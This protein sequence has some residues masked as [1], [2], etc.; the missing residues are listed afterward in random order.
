MSIS[1]FILPSTTLSH[2]S[3]DYRV[4]SSIKINL[5]KIQDLGNQWQ[6]NTLAAAASALS[7][8]TGNANAGNLVGNRMFFANDYMV[9][10]FWILAEWAGQQ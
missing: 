7:Q 9:R 3:S 4:A 6:S 1:E 5:T 10:S 2:E 8:D